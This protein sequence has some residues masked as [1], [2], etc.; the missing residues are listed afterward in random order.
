MTA[1]TGVCLLVLVAPFEALTPVVRLPGQALTNVE[2]VLCV[3]LSAWLISS[4][5]CRQL[6]RW[7]TSVT[8]PW[9]TVLLAATIAA[10]LAPI[11]R[12]NALHMVGRSTMAFAVFLLTING[13]T[14]T[15]RINGVLVAAAT[16][17]AIVGAFVVLDYFGVSSVVRALRGFRPGLSFVGNQVRASGPFQYPTIASMYLE[18]IFALT[19][20]LTVAVAA[21]GKWWQTTVLVAVLALVGEAIVLTFTR[22]GL[23]TVAATLVIV[24]VL[25]G[26]RSGFD[27][28]FAVVAVVAALVPAEIV[29]SRSVDA[30]RLRLT[31]ETQEEWYRAMI[32]APLTI[33][34]R[35]GAES[36]VPIRVSNVG[37]ITWTTD[38]EQ[39]F[40]LASHWLHAADDRVAVWEGVRTEFPA[41][42]LA[43]D[44]IELDARVKAPTE[45]GSFRLIWD[46]EQKDRLWFSSEPGALI[47]ETRA[48]VSGPP[49]APIEASEVFTFPRP[50]ARPGRFVLWRAALRMLGDRPLTGVGPDNFRLLYG[51]Y[52]GIANADSRVHS[53]SMYVEVLAG[54][55]VIGAS[56]FLW[57]G[58]R[59]IRCLGAAAFEQLPMAAGI[60]AAGAAIAIHGLADMFLSFTAIYIPIAITIGLAVSAAACSEGHAYRI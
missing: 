39:R 16:I 5:V 38:G 43:G 30:L 32:E 28:G 46:I 23:L 3:V 22:S 13:V 29:L 53:N 18:I 31:S 6:P 57:L 35:T 42:V 10:L 44:T 54:T 48:T 15:R 25:Q 55:G 9:L 40:R 59:V 56:A 14:T 27:R 1:W 45:P 26:L 19:L 4:A 52:A 36:R 33:S 17:G 2:I 7:R 49:L 37:R 11:D 34:L 47:A 50:V 8:T 41:P 21:T 60:V 58:W 24:A 51:R 12:W 20:G